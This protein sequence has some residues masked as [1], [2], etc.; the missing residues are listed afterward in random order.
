VCE[1][2]LPVRETLTFSPTFRR[3]QR[4]HHG[5]DDRLD[6]GLH[7]RRLPVELGGD[8][9]K[10]HWLVTGPAVGAEQVGDRHGEGVGHLRGRRPPASGRRRRKVR[11]YGIVPS[12]AAGCHYANCRS[13]LRSE[14]ASNRHRRISV[15]AIAGFGDR[16]QRNPHPVACARWRVSMLT[17]AQTSTLVA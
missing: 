8:P 15:I 14:E 13:S 10:D 4:A 2:G 5:L 7:V 12:H 11:F 6:R 1:G 3:P 9:A 16:I 17:A